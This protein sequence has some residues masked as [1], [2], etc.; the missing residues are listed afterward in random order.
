MTA[1]MQVDL[2]RLPAPIAVQVTDVRALRA[3]LQVEL[4]KTWPEAA[5]LRASDPVSK[6]LDL[7][8]VRLSLAQHRANDAAL[9]V[10]LA[11]ARGAD[12]DHLAAPYET[13]R[14]VLDPGDPQ[15]KPARPP[16]MESDDDLRART[17]LAPPGAS[18]AGPRAAYVRLALRADGR[19]ADASCTSPAPGHVT[20]AL[21]S[22]EAGG[23]ASPDLLSVVTSALTPEDVRP[24]T[25]Y[26]TV[27]GATPVPFEVRATLEL[28]SGPAAEAVMAAARTS[29]TSYLARQRRLGE[30]VT[31]DGLYAS[32]RVEGVRAIRLESPG[33][34]IRADAISW[35][36]CRSVIMTVAETA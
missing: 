9:S 24:L 34:D 22:T 23:I 26:V 17:T 10:M 27:R 19:V 5:D 20:V 11:Y 14:R 36:E 30:W 12:L 29:L 13:F 7:M 16:V 2:S 3:E 1:Q 4:A 32:M 25:D 31:L 28:Y 6:I 21:L 35:P 15:A 33:Q 18:V 8:A